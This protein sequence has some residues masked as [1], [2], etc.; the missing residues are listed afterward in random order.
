METKY[1]TVVKIDGEYAYLSEI[2]NESEEVF[3]AMALL[4]FGIDVGARLKCEYF[5]YTLIDWGK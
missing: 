2:G 4:P 5:Q 3:V 1:Y